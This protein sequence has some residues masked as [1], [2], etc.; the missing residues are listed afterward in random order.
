MTSDGTKV[1]VAFGGIV[2]EEVVLGRALFRP[3][4][5]GSSGFVLED[6]E[7][8]EAA[9]A[10]P[11]FVALGS[12]G[13]AGWFLEGSE[14]ATETVACLQSSIFLLVVALSGSWSVTIRFKAEGRAHSSGEVVFGNRRCRFFGP[15]SCSMVS[16]VSLVT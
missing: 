11:P 6:T 12:I 7:E 5:Q 15:F 16:L 10:R 8:D 1:L 14:D 4:F 3:F 13:T 9:A 2:G